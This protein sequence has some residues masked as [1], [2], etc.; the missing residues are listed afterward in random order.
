MLLRA[1]NNL[2]RSDGFSRKP[3]KAHVNELAMSV[4][5]GEQEL[6]HAQ[7]ILKVKSNCAGRQRVN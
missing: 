6:L 7:G 5:Q 3:T 2:T 4:S 1:P